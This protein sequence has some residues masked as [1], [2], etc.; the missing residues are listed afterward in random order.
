MQYIAAFILSLFGG[1]ASWLMQFIAKRAAVTLSLAATV[2]AMTLALFLMY[3]GIMA[4][5]VYVIP[6]ELIR[7]VFTEIWPDNAD[8]CIGSIIASE[9]AAFIYGHKLRMMS[10]LAMR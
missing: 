7:M 4:T 9:V 5:L 1:L 8:L 6:N 2:V 3:K 10:W